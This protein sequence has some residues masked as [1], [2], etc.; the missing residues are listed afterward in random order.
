M[1]DEI[2]LTS[3]WVAIHPKKK[4]TEEPGA[5]LFIS[6]MDMLRWTDTVQVLQSNNEITDRGFPIFF[7]ERASYISVSGGFLM[8]LST[9]KVKS[10][11]IFQM[12]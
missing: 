4:K 10:D 5:L 7:R 12:S 6:Q 1:I 2:I 8:F 11:S 3:N 9:N